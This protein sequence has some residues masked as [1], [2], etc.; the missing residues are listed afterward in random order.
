MSNDAVTLIKEHVQ[1]AEIVGRYTQLQKRGTRYVARCPI[2]QE[3]TPSFNLDPQKGLYHCFGCGSGGDLIRFVQDME[4]L[5][6]VEALD[7]LAEIAGIELPK[8]R[9]HGPSRDLIERI[10]AINLAAVEYFQKQL[11]KAPPALEYLK[12]RG[13]S[14]ATIKLFKIGFADNRWEGLYEHLRKRF[15]HDDLM[16]SGLF[17]MGKKGT[18]YDIF[19]ERVIFPIVDAF[20]HVIAFGGRLLPG[21]EGPKYIN[22]PETPLYT[23]GKHL[24]N[25][26]FAKPFLKRDPVVVV[27]EGYMDVL[28]VYQSGVGAVIASLGTAFTENQGKLLKRYAQK[29]L[30]NFDGDQA[31]FKAARTSIETF[32]QIDLEVGVVSLPDN[33]DP[34]DFIRGQGVDAYRRQL[35]RADT[36]FDF[37]IT[38]LGQGG[39][40]RQD[41]HLRSLLV[42]EL[43]QSLRKITDPVVRDF[44]LDKASE[45]LEVPRHV[46]QQ[47]YQR[48]SETL[49]A[50]PQPPKPVVEP[51]PTFELTHIEKKYLYLIMHQI[52]F[53]QDL[54]EDQQETLPKILAQIFRNRGGLLEFIYAEEGQ[55][56]H[57][58]IQLV[59]DTLRPVIMEV[60]FSEGFQ[61]VEDEEVHKLYYDLLKL[62]FEKLQDRNRRILAQ[63]T[64]TDDTRR[65]QLMRQNFQYRRELGKIEEMIRSGEI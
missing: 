57:Q 61:T 2:H 31:G 34:D 25:L 50:K 64:P 37:L 26:H 18:A 58:R 52:P 13:L 29:A 15:E 30:L 7:F 19:R 12:E 10:R 1:L 9:G 42:Q 48:H 23:K 36:F 41:P 63:L 20:G 54:N 21:Q 3:K 55:D 47:V 16:T 6:F 8:N 28:Q 43:C 24:Y 35:E 40:Y 59:Q 60:F 5:S 53:E 4:H 14:S 22:S 38:H 65:H 51:P 17:K 27:V 46:I 32:L 62:M 11:A 44:Y 39:G 56:I 33:Q 49:Q 45:D